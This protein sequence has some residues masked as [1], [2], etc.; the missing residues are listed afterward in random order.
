MSNYELK[1]DSVILKQIS[2]ISKNR[3]LS[4]LLSKIFDKIAEHGTSIGKLLDPQIGV[5]E[6][7]MKHPPLRLYYV[8]K[9]NSNEIRILEYGMKTSYEKQQLMIDRILGKLIKF[10]LVLG[11]RLFPSLRFLGTLQLSFLVA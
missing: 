6:I 10:L 11:Y 1:F 3:H 5:Y 8:R 2:K 4:G 9:A 7:K